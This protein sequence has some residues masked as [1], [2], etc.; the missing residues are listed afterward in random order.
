MSKSFY[1]KILYFYDN[2]FSQGNLIS[3]PLC[4]KTV[5]ELFFANLPLGFKN[6]TFINVLFSKPKV[7]FTFY[8]RLR[9]RR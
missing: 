7:E 2:T 4:S 3:R 5:S 8:F 9:K 1:K 6:W